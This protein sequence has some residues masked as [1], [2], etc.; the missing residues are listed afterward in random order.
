MG[1]PSE[2]AKQIVFWHK[3]VNSKYIRKKIGIPSEFAI[4]KVNS[5]LIREEDSKFEVNSR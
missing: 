5:K 1:I 4:K 2:F 3:N